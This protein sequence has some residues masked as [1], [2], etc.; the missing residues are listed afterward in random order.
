MLSGLSSVLVMVLFYP[1]RLAIYIHHC[2]DG[3]MPIT[4]VGLVI[5]AA[6]AYKEAMKNT[7]S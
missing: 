7:V 1:S 3:G 5:D 6:E 2:M 4:P